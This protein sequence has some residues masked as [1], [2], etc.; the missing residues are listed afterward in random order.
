M[1]IYREAAENPFV[2]GG[3]NPTMGQVL[4]ESKDQLRRQL[5]AD[6][7]IDVYSCG[8]RDIESSAI[9]RRVLATPEFLVANGLDPTVTSST[10]PRSTA[11]RSSATRAP[12]RSPS[13]HSC[14]CR[15]SRAR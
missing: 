4:P 9:G 5:L 1:A 13:S 10:S 7:W 15:R 2:G 11:S 8:R 12:A 14:G 6:P 3:A